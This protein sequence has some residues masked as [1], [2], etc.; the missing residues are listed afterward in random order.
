MRV[1]AY[2]GRPFSYYCDGCRGYNVGGTDPYVNGRGQVAYP[3]GSYALV[4]RNGQTC[5]G[6]YCPDCARKH[7]SAVDQTRSVTSYFSDTRGR[8]RSLEDVIN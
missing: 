4:D 1:T 6:V 7:A 8:A 3:P 5:S 2:I